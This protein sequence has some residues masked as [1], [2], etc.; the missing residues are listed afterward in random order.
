MEV[1]CSEETMN[2]GKGLSNPSALSTSHLVHCCWARQNLK[3]N[4]EPVIAAITF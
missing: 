4:A 1:I 2:N 3:Q